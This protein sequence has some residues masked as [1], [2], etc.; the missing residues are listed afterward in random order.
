MEAIIAGRAICCCNGSYQPSL[1]E[2]IVGSGWII[3]AP[4]TRVECNGAC[5]TSGYLKAVNA[6]RA[7][8]QGIHTILLVVKA[9]CSGYNIKARAVT[10]GCDNLR[11]C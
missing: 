9:I 5:P 10:I 1:S 11:G 2:D 8:L 6:Y 4:V 3:Q 7:E